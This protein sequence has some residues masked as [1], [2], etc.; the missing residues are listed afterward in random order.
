MGHISPRLK[1]PS[2]WFLSF[3]IV[4]V[5]LLISF[6]LCAE[7]HQLPRAFIP[8]SWYQ[9]ASPTLPPVSASTGFHSEGLRSLPSFTV[10]NREYVTGSSLTRDTLHSNL[11]VD[12]IFL[13]PKTFRGGIGFNTY[14]PASDLSEEWQ[15]AKNISMIEAVHVKA[16]DKG[17]RFLCAMQ[18]PYEF[19]G[20]AQ[21]VEE[22]EAIVVPTDTTWDIN[23][24][25]MLS[26][27]RCE[28][29]QDIERFITRYRDGE[30]HVRDAR[31]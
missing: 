15:R 21:V 17:S 31:R 1:A 25:D 30:L 27:L 5:P 3:L 2:A 10:D 12:V 23:A 18:L 6:I 22:F 7:D 16:R 9:T 29:P 24:N 28:V 20:K 13:G 19:A 4:Q 8:S 14:T 26:I 11:F